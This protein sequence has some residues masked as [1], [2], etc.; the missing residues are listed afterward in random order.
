MAKWNVN[1]GFNFA[2]WEKSP[3]FAHIPNKTAKQH[4]R[5]PSVWRVDT[6]RRL[7]TVINLQVILIFTDMYLKCTKFD[8]N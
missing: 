5:N 8:T 6:N 1:E 3:L 2:L 4:E 7:R